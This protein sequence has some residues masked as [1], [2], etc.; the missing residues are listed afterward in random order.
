MAG[1][2]KEYTHYKW[3]W[4]H[5]H[6]MRISFG[7]CRISDRFAISD[8]VRIFPLYH[9]N[10][11]MSKS[12]KNTNPK[13]IVTVGDLDAK[14]FGRM[15]Y[16]KITFNPDGTLPDDKGIRCTA[17]ADAFTGTVELYDLSADAVVWSVPASHQYST[18]GAYLGTVL[19]F[20]LADL[21]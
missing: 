12:M 10:I 11:N 18:Q 8:S 3:K 21:V 9:L 13:A 14:Y 17:G 6:L 5:S 16:G 4:R 2:I 15:A 7:I 19:D 20:A 1:C